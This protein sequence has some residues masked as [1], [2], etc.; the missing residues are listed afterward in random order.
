[1]FI[2]LTGAIGI[3]FAA[4]LFYLVSRVQLES[5]PGTEDSETGTLIDTAD[6]DAE[7]LIIYLTIR[8]GAKD[9]LWAEYKICFIF[10]ALFG[11]VIFILVSH[12]ADSAGVSVWDFNAGTS[13]VLPLNTACA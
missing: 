13:R 1:M 5:G 4:F 2:A 7:L 3:F 12:T 9:F 10:I 8:Q 11:A 6:S